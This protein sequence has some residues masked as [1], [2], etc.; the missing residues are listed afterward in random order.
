[1]TPQVSAV[2]LRLTIVGVVLSVALA[3]TTAW[4]SAQSATKKALTVEDYTRW[5][6]I[7]D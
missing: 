3:L 2:R 6:S 4:P 5:R 1:M 7:S